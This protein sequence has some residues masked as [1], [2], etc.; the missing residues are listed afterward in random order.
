MSVCLSETLWLQGGI[1]ELSLLQERYHHL[2]QE[3][4]SIQQDVSLIEHIEQITFLTLGNCSQT[5]DV[6]K[7]SVES[8]GIDLEHLE[9]RHKRALDGASKSSI[10]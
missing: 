4:G 7:S 2:S 9:S 6:P 8:S 5:S 1:L 3:N 10:A